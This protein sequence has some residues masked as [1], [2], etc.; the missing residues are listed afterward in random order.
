MKIFLQACS[1]FPNSAMAWHWAEAR[2]SGG[3]AGESQV[4]PNS[5]T[6]TAFLGTPQDQ[7]GSSGSQPLL[8]SILHS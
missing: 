4:A 6:S 5:K 1:S 3:V 7:K 8:R 2:W